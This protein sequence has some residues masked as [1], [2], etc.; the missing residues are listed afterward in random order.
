MSFSS[1]VIRKFVY[2]QVIRKNMQEHLVV[3]T[4]EHMMLMMK[5]Q[6]KFILALEQKSIEIEKVFVGNGKL[7]DKLSKTEAELNYLKSKSL[8]VP[9]LINGIHH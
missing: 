8:Q 1:K 9:Q 2:L 5:E 3:S 7:C 4:Q 6:K